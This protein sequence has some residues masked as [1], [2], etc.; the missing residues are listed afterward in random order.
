MHGPVA[1]DRELSAWCCS[2]AVAAEP[3]VQTARISFE[4]YT[5]QD[6]GVDAAQRWYQVFTDLGVANLRIRG[7]EAGDEIGIHERGKRDAPTYRVTGQIATGNVLVLPGGK[8]TPRD[9]V[10]LKQ[11]LKSLAEQGVDGVTGKPARF[12]LTEAQYHEVEEDLK[13][14][15]GFSTLDLPAAEAV[16]KIAGGLR[17]GVEIAP[18]ARADLAKRQVGENLAGLS[19]GTALAVILQPAGLVFA[20]ERG[21]MA[22]TTHYRIGPL[23]AGHEV[24]PPGCGERQARPGSRP[25]L[26]QVCPRRDR[27]DTRGGSDRGDSEAAGDSVFVGPLR[28]RIASER[29]GSSRGQAGDQE[30]SLRGNPAEDS[31]SG[32]AAK[33]AARG[34]RRQAVLVDHDAAAGD[35]RPEIAGL[36]WPLATGGS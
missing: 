10:R 21:R 19:A 15:V 35:A 12:G 30:A 11:W 33:R 13:R 16:A 22:K 23:A 7:A 8:F 2:V 3:R 1:N 36:P 14:P 34:R 6:A 29:S 28:A 27:R 32:K 25:R 4:L 20:P 5:D 9:S 24:W 26:V 31:L 17:H 18:A